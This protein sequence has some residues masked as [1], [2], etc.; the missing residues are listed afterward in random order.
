M[1]KK[2]SFVYG[3]MLICISSII[4]KLISVFYKIPLARIL[5]A[6]GMGVYYLI[7][8]VYAFLSTFVSNS[9][10][11]SISKRVSGKISQDNYVGAYKIFRVSCISMWGLGIFLSILL[12]CFSKVIATLQGVQGAYICYIAVA[13]AIIFVGQ[14]S[15]YKGFFQGLQDMSPSAVSQVLAQIFKLIFA[16]ALSKFFSP[17]GVFWGALGGFIGL[18]LSEFICFLYFVIYYFIFKKRH[19]EIFLEQKKLTK[20]DFSKVFK[21]ALPFLLTSIILPM[22][23]LVDSFLIVNIL[24]S[25]GFDNLFATSLLGLNSGV[26]STLIN[27]PSTF[28]MALCVTIVPYITKSVINKD[29]SGVSNKS[30]MALKLIL[31]VALPCFLVFLLFSSDIIG[32]LYVF[33]SAYEKNV[34]V[35]LCILSSINVFYLSILNIT[36]A[37]LQSINRSFVPVISLLCALVLKVVLEIL[38]ISTPMLNIAGAVISSSICYAVSGAINIIYFR[39]TI[40]IKPKFFRSFLSPFLSSIVAIFMIYLTKSLVQNLISY[41]F[42]TIL[43]LCLGGIAYIICLF[44]FRTFTKEEREVLFRLKPFSQK[45]AQKG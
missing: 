15:V 24:K 23:T 16:L 34:A 42:C 25:M 12:F 19:K 30:I 18:S 4:C 17:L 6:E 45:N 36:T 2:R 11:L 37:L 20:R 31:I 33:S 35:T 7:F 28:A 1:L 40:E 38:L 13:P 22:A 32:L 44:L 14:S 26:V 10:T 41:A 3:A 9:F 39:K 5:G 29:Y 21:S 27:L 43:S 8:P